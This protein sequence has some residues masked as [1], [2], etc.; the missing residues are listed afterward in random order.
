MRR[1]IGERMARSVREQ[2]QFSIWRDVD[3]TAANEKRKAPGAS[4]TD[5]I[6]AAAAKT[7][8]DHP[9]LRAR[10]EERELATSEAA[11]IGPALP[12]E[13]GLPVAVR[14]HAERKRLQE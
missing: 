12:L 8:R 4:Y 7:L 11:N 13:A 9:R 10:I 5:A 1:A 2:P 6:V 14:P 3:M